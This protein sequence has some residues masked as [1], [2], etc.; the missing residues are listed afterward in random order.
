MVRRP[1]EET[2]ALPA[3]FKDWSAQRAEARGMTETL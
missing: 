1:E 3:D 2:P